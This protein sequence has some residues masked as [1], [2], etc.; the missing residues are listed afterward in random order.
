MNTKSSYYLPIIFDFYNSSITLNAI[1]KD[2]CNFLFNDVFIRAIDFYGSIAVLLLLN[3]EDFFIKFYLIL[4][5]DFKLFI[6]ELL[7]LRLYFL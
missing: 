6:E 2:F 5:L 3:R 7:L 4:P 1:S